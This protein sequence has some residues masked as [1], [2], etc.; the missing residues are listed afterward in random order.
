LPLPEFYVCKPT[1]NRIKSTLIIVSEAISPPRELSA[2]VLCD[3][4]AE[5]DRV[6]MS[7]RKILQLG[8]QPVPRASG[9]IVYAKSSNNTR[10]AKLIFIPQVTVRIQFTRPGSTEIEERAVLT[11][12]TCSEDDWNAAVT[13]S[14]ASS[15]VPETN[16]VIPLGPPIL[17]T[18]Q[19]SPIGHRM[20]GEG[21]ASDRSNE[22]CAVGEG[23]LEK[24]GA[25]FNH[26]RHILEIGEEV[27]EED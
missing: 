3:G 11:N 14:T 7:A 15:P 13:H 1:D 26:V 25:H 24:L 27:I 9:G 21:I 10:L 6:T 18:V 2:V 12:V 23:L 22:T 8:L 4:G 5:G 17:A 16:S 19:L 20:F